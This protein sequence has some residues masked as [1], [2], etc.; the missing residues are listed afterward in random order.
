MTTTTGAGPGG[1]VCAEPETAGPRAGGAARLPELPAFASVDAADAKDLSRVLFAR[2]DALREG[3]PEYSYVRN[4]LVELNLAL[5]R[6]AVRR[7]GVRGESYED[8][9]Q[10]GTIG[11]IKAINRFDPGRGIEFPTFA[12]P[13][14][15]GEIKRYFRDTTWAVHV[16][17]RLQELRSDLARATAQLEQEHGRAPTPAEIAR[18]LDVDGD[19]VAEGLLAANGYASSSLDQPADAESAFSDHIGRPD[20]GLEKVEDL[21]AL[22]PLIA[23]LPAR[24]RHILAMRYSAE[25]TQSAIGEELGI[26]QMHVSRILTRTLA[27]LRAKL[28]TPR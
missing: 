20:A 18:Y 16:P 24:D 26:S 9:V 11:L 23:E 5:V 14:V 28:T 17:R 19:T 3:S 12:M 22:K 27:R 13:T 25:M 21:H 15:M 7:V 6:H 2:L 8:V 4:S 10:V 1:A